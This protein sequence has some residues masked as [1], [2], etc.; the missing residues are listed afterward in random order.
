MRSLI[1]DVL[2]PAE[3]AVD[4]S[5]DAAS[6]VWS[7]YF[8]LVG[9]HEE[10]L[11]LQEELDHLRIEIQRNSELVI[12]AERLRRLLDLDPGRET[13][14]VARVT[15]GDPSVARRTATLDKGRASGVEPGAPV[16]TPA[17]I[18]GRVIYAARFSSI[19][20]LMTDPT[21]A[22]GAVVQESRVQGIVRG[23]GAP[24]LIFEHSEDGEDLRPGQ[25]V[26][27]SGSE[28]IYPKGVPIGVIVSIETV[29]DL[30]STAIVEPAADLGRL[31]EVLVLDVTREDPPEP[32]PIPEPVGS[33]RP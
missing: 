11:R 5:V 23:T 20:Q 29:T 15:G 26:V 24:R 27:T 3:R 13:S 22:V 31:E 8:A 21:S 10:N 30:V 18:V 33:P 16:R 32:E 7:R 9:T 2:T 14:R 1:L 17:G 19:M 6:S 28:R 25:I 4:R 12:E